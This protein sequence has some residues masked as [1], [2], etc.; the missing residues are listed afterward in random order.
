MAQSPVPRCEAS[1]FG[2]VAYAFPNRSRERSLAFSASISRSRAGALVWSDASNRRA[3]SETSETARLNA[4]ALAWDGALN[5]DNFRTNCRAEA[6][7]SAWVAGGS[8]LNSVL[9]LR[10]MHLLPCPVGARSLQERTGSRISDIC[11][12][13]WHRKDLAAHGPGR[14]M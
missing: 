4:S 7:I 5:P 10:H 13:F 11:P 8:K 2:P 1:H 14:T 12:A 3:L 6:W 9:M